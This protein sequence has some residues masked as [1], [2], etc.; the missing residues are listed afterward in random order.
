LSIYE[1]EL[2]KLEEE[3]KQREAKKRELQQALNKLKNYKK[4]FE[5]AGRTDLVEQIEKDIEK[6]EN[7]L[8]SLENSK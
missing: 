1:Q 7:E 8:K 4:Q 5:Q 2:K 6:V 3:N